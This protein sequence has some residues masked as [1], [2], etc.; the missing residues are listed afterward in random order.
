L[1]SLARTWIAASGQTAVGLVGGHARRSPTFR[2]QARP[3]TTHSFPGDAGRDHHV[4]SECSCLKAPLP[5]NRRRRAKA[6]CNLISCSV[7]RVRGT[8]KNVALESCDDPHGELRS[9][10]AMPTR[11]ESITA[12]SDSGRVAWQQSFANQLLAKN[13]RLKLHTQALAY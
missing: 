12:Y 2:A 9:S 3:E 10:P 7:Q 6:C 5:S 13:L 4:I 11:R 1:D 8:I